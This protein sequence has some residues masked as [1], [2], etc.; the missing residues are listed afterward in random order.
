MADG[1]AR[2]GGGE[3]AERQLQPAPPQV[4]VRVVKEFGGSSS[5][6]MLTRTNY[7]EWATQMKWKLRAR[8]WWRAIEEDDRTEDAQVGVMEALMAS[9]PAEYHE[10]LGAKDTAKQAW[11]ML[12]SLRVGS[13]R[14]KRARIQQLRRE[15]NDIKFKSGESVED[16][17]LRLQSLATQLAT[18]SKKVDDEDLN[19]KLFAP[20]RQDTRSSPCPSRPCWTSPRCLWRTWP[21]GCG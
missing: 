12:E 21:G 19:T 1:A 4:E 18:Y 5:W 13:D 9:T 16:F 20:C 7:G 6:P 14:A 11:E 15:L 2:N 3:G 8:K 17:T 10:A